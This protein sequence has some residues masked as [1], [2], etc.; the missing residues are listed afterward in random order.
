MS[1]IDNK[2]INALTIP[3]AWSAAMGTAFVS[4]ATPMTQALIAIA[5]GELYF[6]QLI[7]TLPEGSLDLTRAWYFSGIIIT[8]IFLRGVLHIFSTWAWAVA[9]ST[10]SRLHL[11][12]ARASL[13]TTASS[14]SSIIKNPTAV[15]EQVVNGQVMWQRL[16]SELPAMSIAA[17]IIITW[18]AP[19]LGMICAIAWCLAAWFLRHAAKEMRTSVGNDDDARQ[20]WSAFL[21]DESLA[22][23]SVRGLHLEQGRQQVLQRLLRSWSHLRQQQQQAQHTVT[24]PLH[25]VLAG[26]LAMIAVIGSTLV[27]HGQ[28]ELCGFITTLVV[29][30]SVAIRMEQLPAM[31]TQIATGDMAQQQ[32]SQFNLKHQQKQIIFQHIKSA[33]FPLPL[34]VRLIPIEHL[35]ADHIPPDVLTLI[36]G[37]IVGLVGRTGD[38][39]E[40]LASIWS[41]ITTDN[42]WRSV[43]GS[44]AHGWKELPPLHSPDRSHFI[45]S[46]SQTSPLLSGSIADNIRLGQTDLT[47]DEL[48]RALNLASASDLVNCFSDGLAHHIGEQGICLS[49]GQRQRL[50]LA[51]AIA[52]RPRFLCLDQATSELDHV[53]ERS[54]FAGLRLLA[55][56]PVEKTG[57]LIVSSSAA[58]LE[59]CDRIVVISRGQIIAYGSHAEL[60]ETC[61]LYPGLLGLEQ[62]SGAQQNGAQQNGIQQ[63]KGIQQTGA[64]QQCA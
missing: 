33:Q 15:V 44:D 3:I 42:A 61:H 27:F 20:Q 7:T 37:E 38:G 63:Q 40:L 32:L 62:A 51:R 13:N 2:N 4:A 25:L 57:V 23:R 47:N 18:Y 6:G 30:T 59:H 1:C 16:L 12:V 55:R 21:R 52:A 49:G 45:Q 50:C 9:T 31:L 36:P 56:D 11:T 54:V 39:K 48:N 5:I 26:S 43:G 60:L 22:T 10:A 24:L 53:N 46:V 35:L 17:V 41:G 14:A 28:L 19:L 58:L 29:S 34:Q 64:Q 8:L